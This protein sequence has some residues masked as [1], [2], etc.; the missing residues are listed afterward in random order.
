MQSV[1]MPESC[2][3]MN[4]CGTE[5]PIWLD[6]T[7]PPND[8]VE[9]VMKVCANRNMPFGRK[10]CFQTWDIKVKNCG[11]F[12]VYNLPRT[13]GCNMAYCAGEFNIFL[14]V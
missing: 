3:D 7:H 4:H 6:G 2:V 11:T 9:H 12:F 13:P 1:K 10:C 8:G 5:V 14:D